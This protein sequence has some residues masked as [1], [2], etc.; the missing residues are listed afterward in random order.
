MQLKVVKKKLQ[1]LDQEIAQTRLAKHEPQEMII[2]NQ[3]IVLSKKRKKTKIQ[4]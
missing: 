2:S 4:G 1:D 3:T